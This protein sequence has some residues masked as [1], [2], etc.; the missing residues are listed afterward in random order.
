MLTQWIDTCEVQRVSL[1]GGLVLRLDDYTS[2]SSPDH[3]DYRF[4]RWRTFRPKT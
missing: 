2:W 1:E 3:C 4:P